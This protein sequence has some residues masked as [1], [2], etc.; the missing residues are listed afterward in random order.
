MTITSRKEQNYGKIKNKTL[1]SFEKCSIFN[2]DE[3][4]AVFQTNDLVSLLAVK[5]FQSEVPCMRIRFVI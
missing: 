2:E 1:E 5:Y 3:H 4:V